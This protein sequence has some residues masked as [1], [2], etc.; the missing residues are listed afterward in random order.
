MSNWLRQQGYAIAAAFAHLRQAPANFLI[1]MLVVAMTL[2]LPFGGATLLDNLRPV[3]AQL[4]VDAEI[5]VARC[6]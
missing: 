3:S 4:E 6:W 1:N 2:A 5:S